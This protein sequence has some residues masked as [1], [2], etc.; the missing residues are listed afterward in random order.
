MEPAQ[1]LIPLTVLLPLFAGLALLFPVPAFDDRRTVWTYALFS[2]I[3][4]FLA[5]LIVAIN[6]DWA[7][8]TFQMMRDVPWVP[9]F[10]LSFGYGLDSISL[11]LVLLSTFIMP[12]VVLATL[13]ESTP[14]P[15]GFYLWLLLVESAMVASFIATDAMFFFLCF[16]FT[17]IPLYFLIG[18]F[19]DSRRRL[20]AG[21]FFIYTFVGS[22]LMFAGLLYVAWVAHGQTGEW[23]FSFA[24]LT[25]AAQQMSFS[26]QAWVLLAFL[27]GFAVKVPIFPLH[28]WQPLAYRESPTAGTVVLAAV[29]AKLGTY[30]LLRFALPMTPDAVVAAAPVIGVLAT[31]GILYAGIVAWVQKDLKTLIAY[32]SISHLGFIVLG[33]FALDHQDL[34]ANG[35]TFYMVSHGVTTGAL[36]L[37]AGMLY[38]RFQTYEMHAMS[39]LGRQMPVWAFFT[40]FFTFASIGLPG[41]S[42]FVGEFLTLIGTFSSPR[43][44]LGVPYAV[45]AGGGII[46]GA[47]YMLYMTGKVVFGPEKLP[48]P[49]PLPGETPT[50]VPDLTGREIWALAPL[51]VVALVLGVYP[52]PVLN[53]LEEPVAQMTVAARRSTNLRGTDAAFTQ[54]EALPGAT[55]VI[56]DAEGA[57]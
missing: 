33:L 54:A 43:G 16:E 53:S 51:A 56:R 14:N 37:C 40:M 34:G 32:S 4:T 23:S 52:A 13:P 47:V 42:G 17:L 50:R 6:F 45:F 22:M 11:W 10:G 20:A 29:L 21:M 27:A 46:L 25:A 39:G 49:A 26:E 5:S 31:I 15:R 41:L 36:F 12:L 2:T 7:Q 8:P 55:L 30:G 9:Q 35:A 44:V 28:T 19:G 1:I 38:D 18:Q 24:R 48:L 3:V 57:E